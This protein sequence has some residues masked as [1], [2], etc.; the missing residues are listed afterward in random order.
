MSLLEVDGGYSLGASGRANH[1]IVIGRNL[2]KGTP[3][4]HGIGKNKL[5]CK[6]TIPMR[7][8]LA[9]DC[10]YS[11]SMKVNHQRF[12]FV[13]EF[14]TV[15]HGPYRNIEMQMLSIDLD[16][17]ANFTLQSNLCLQAIAVPFFPKV[18]FNRGKKTYIYIPIHNRYFRE[19]KEVKYFNCSLLLDQ[20]IINVDC[21]IDLFKLFL[22]SLN[23]Y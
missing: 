22:D 4:D 17:G 8:C 11:D 3:T 13:N 23:Y 15:D 2:G 18:E 20:T 12:S 16:L 10:I 9:Q 6:C 14:T 1:L 21:I 5:V 19:A 7:V